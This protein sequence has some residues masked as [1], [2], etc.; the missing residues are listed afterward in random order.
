M[1]KTLTQFW[2]FLTT[3]FSAGVHG[4]QAVENVCIIAEETS[5]NW[6]DNTRLQRAIDQE[7]AKKALAAAVKGIAPK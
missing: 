6:K 1:S 5:G 3:L 4:A 2:L 7:A